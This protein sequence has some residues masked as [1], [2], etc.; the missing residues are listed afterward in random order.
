[1]HKGLMPGDLLD[2]F[3]FV[4]F[5]QQMAVFHVN[6]LLHPI[7]RNENKLYVKLFRDNPLK[8]IRFSYLVLNPAHHH[9]LLQVPRSM[10]KFLRG[11][12][13]G[14]SLLLE[15][16]PAESGNQSEVTLKID[17]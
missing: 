1:M 12:R 7:K 14:S 5:E 4:L 16:D 10:T 8:K 2:Y 9:I 6:I 15:G 13:P 11:P 3:L 17:T